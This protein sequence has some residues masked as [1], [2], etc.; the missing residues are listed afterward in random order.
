M[1]DRP[2][3]SVELS[4]QGG[5]RFASSDDYGHSVTVDAPMNDGDEFE[6]MMP[7]GLLLTS[8]AG[9]SA[10]D[11]VNILR[12]Q[13]QNV[14]ALEISV[15]GY[16]QPDPP[17]TYEN[18]ELRYVVKGAGLKRP[19]VERAIKLSEEKYCSVGATLSGRCEITST[20]EI[21]EDD[22]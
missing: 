11:V 20:Y 18:I 8:L 15:R 14:T 12:R 21:V 16:Q 2:S 1:T 13:R 4:W 22:A 10:I 9:C 6:G 19:L 7:G 17:W 5:F 3:T